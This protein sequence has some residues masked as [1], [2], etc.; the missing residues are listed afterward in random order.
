MSM[1]KTK[2]TEMLGVKYPIV[3]GTMMHISNAEFTAAI[4]N[5]GGL[6]ILASAIYQSREAFS[7]ALDQ[8]IELTDKPFAVNLNLFPAMHP[9]DNNDY[10]DVLLEIGVKIVETSGHSAPQELCARFKEAGLTWMHKCV[11]VRY[12]LKVQE[13]GAD[14]VTV[15]G[16]E[17]GGATGKLDI[18]TLVL[19]PRVVESLH[20]PVIGGGGV[21]DGRGLVAIL[22]LGAQG[23]IMGTRLLAT[24][25]APIHDRL[26]E[27]LVK[28]GELDTMLVMR[29]IGAT[30][31]VWINTAAKKVAELEDNQAGL[32]EILKIAT[33]EKAK[34]MYNEGDLDV[35][36]ISC[37]QGIGMAHDIPTVK[38]L[39]DRIMGDA[40]DVAKGL[41][42]D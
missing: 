26:K 37:G 9:I 42:A 28:A 40:T 23:V 34:K 13:M 29:S 31:R 41:V 5:A 27:A 30:H 20:L 36:I 18:G 35:G 11:G 8:L 10:L 24:K 2:M 19:V 32:A 33:G 22:A 4:S 38:E 17:N 6:G 15:V 21:S 14:M 3:G 39:F 25:E 7:E 16:Y 1:F 12:A